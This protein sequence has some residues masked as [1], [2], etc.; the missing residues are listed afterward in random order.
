M[1][2]SNHTPVV[3]VISEPVSF[4]H[5]ETLVTANF[6]NA[7]VQGGG[8]DHGVTSIWTKNAD[9]SYHIFAQVQK[10]A[11]KKKDHPSLAQKKSQD[12]IQYVDEEVKRQMF[13]GMK[14]LSLSASTK[15]L[16]KG[17]KSRNQ[18]HSAKG[19]RHREG[20]QISIEV[21]RWSLSRETNVITDKWERTHSPPRRARR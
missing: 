21:A 5:L 16:S 2:P 13:P 19:V 14:K 11:L 3:L 7:R 17:L 6:A 18:T 12:H 20:C 4:F 9:Q 10:P 15:R 8:D 1:D